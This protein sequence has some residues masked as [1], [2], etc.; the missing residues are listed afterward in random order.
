VAGGALLLAFV[1]TLYARL[2]FTNRVL[3]SGDILHYFYPYRD[4][5]AEVL[6]NGQI[7]F[8]NPFIFLGAPFLANLQSAVLYPLNWPLIWLSVTGQIYWSAALHTWLLGFGVYL[9]MR[10][11]HYS[12]WAAL[13]SA[14]VL[15]GSGFYGGLIGHINQMNGAAWLPWS[16]LVLEIGAGMSV[17]VVSGSTR[18]RFPGRWSRLLIAV[19]CLSLLVSFTLLAGHAQTAFINLFA[20]GL[21]TLYSPHWRHPRAERSQLVADVGKRLSVYIG[22]VLLGGLLAGGQ[23]VPSLE[24]NRLGLRTVGLTYVEVSSFSLRPLLLH[25]SLLPSYGLVDLSVIFGTLG[26]TEYVAYVGLI[27]LALAVLGAWKGWGHGRAFGLLFIFVGLFLALG[28]WNPTYFV[29]FKLVPG[30]DLFRAP[31]RWMM[32]Y[33]LGMAVLAGIGVGR[34]EVA[35]RERDRGSGPFQRA[36][37]VPMVLGILIFAELL[38]AARALP[39]AH[40]TAPQALLDVRTAPAHLLTD[41]ARDAIHA[42]AA[43]RFLSMSTTTFDP[44]DMADIRRIMRD[45]ASPQLTQQE[46]DDLIVSLKD[47]EILAPNLSLFWR[48]PAVDGFDGGLLP[49]QRYVRA[50]S[51]F[52]PDADLVPDGRLREQVTQMP[53]A[54]LLGLLNVQYVITDKVR[55]LWFQDVYYDRQIGARL[56]PSVVPRIDVP[57]SRPF[58]ATHV[59]LVGFV[60]GAPA[61]LSKIGLQNAAVVDVTIWQDE[62]PVE[63]LGVTAGG[64][65][66]ADFADGRLDSPMADTGGAMI[67]H[68]DVEQGRQEYR[69]RL[70]LTEPLTATRLALHHSGGS[71]DVVVQ[72][73]S[74]YDE[75]TGM[76]MPLLPSDRGRFRLVHSGDVKIYEN[77]DVWPRA[78]LVHDW[79]SAATQDEALSLVR[80]GSVDLRRAVV[81][82]LPVLSGSGPETGYACSADAECNTAGHV[83]L[84]TYAP[85]RVEMYTGGGAPG[86]LVLSDTY[87]PGWHASVDGEEVA[88]HPVNYLFRGVPVPAGEHRV[89]FEFRPESWRSGLWISASGALIW[90]LLAIA[91]LVGRF[92][93]AGASDV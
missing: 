47:Q 44:G 48:V 70:A 24:L 55:D 20:L 37:I 75:R 86:L 46:F 14:L 10:R 19:L 93:Q 40:P 77:L 39:H 3:A 87:Y 76:F 22:G 13:T 78:Y 43:G 83:T 32:I 23:L 6:R 27:G 18:R 17:R 16:I 72:A 45:T 57:V 79:L 67:A 41:P 82:G 61:D 66:D 49:L 92:R 42:G 69:A 58:E 38:L 73:I 36:F 74:L 5:G 90:L 59:D 12:V 30:F 11:W 29:L 84:L 26:Y 15:A 54:N 85:E 80:D 91:A 1:L 7:P 9:L 34:L 50:L 35:C 4:Y 81:E 88:V 28:R 62:N 25:W 65:P 68:R 71:V 31:A 63:Q 53:D 89:V 64:Q 2:L 52:V 51:L 33:T 60:D 8:W 56:S 21:W